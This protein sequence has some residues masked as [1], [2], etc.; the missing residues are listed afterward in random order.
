MA[1]PQGTFECPI[2]LDDSDDE[3]S[4]AADAPISHQNSS[5]TMHDLIR[6]RRQRQQASAGNAQSN[7]SQPRSGI[8]SRSTPRTIPSSKQTSALSQPSTPAQDGVTTGHNQSDG[9]L[10]NGAFYHDKA[11]ATGAFHD[12]A[13]P[14]KALEQLGKKGQPENARNS[15]AR[16]PSIGPS[17][18]ATHPTQSN[19]MGKASSSN[20]QLPS[21]I[22]QNSLLSS[23]RRNNSKDPGN[24][25]TLGTRN[26]SLHTVS[27]E[28]TTCL[29][30]N[31]VKLHKRQADSVKVSST[32]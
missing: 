8:S 11:P 30:K 19:R 16:R 18:P 21:P 24:K 25:A 20:G 1:R 23:T 26:R 5:S 22:P 32:A 10:Q 3:I 17:E 2:E 28:I 29:R 27:E 14:P 15:E 7:N 4:L 31:L 12:L 13:Q 9:S 6:E